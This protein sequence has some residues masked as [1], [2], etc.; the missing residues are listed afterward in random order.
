MATRKARAAE[1][2]PEDLPA[3]DERAPAV[4]KPTAARVLVTCY[5]GRPNDVVRLDAAPL[6]VAVAAGLI[7]PNPDAVAAAAALR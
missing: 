6:A 1:A 7:D 3:Q 5:L 2:P 4:E